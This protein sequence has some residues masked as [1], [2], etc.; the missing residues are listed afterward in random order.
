MLQ[1]IA[2]KD[3]VIE[4]LSKASEM[5]VEAKS[6]QEVKKIMDVAGAAKIYARRQQLGEEAVQHARSIELEAMRRLGELLIETPK[7]S[8]AQGIGKS[9]VPKE[10]HTPTLAELGASK[11]IS[12]LSQQLARMP[13]KE[14]EQVR[15]GIVGMAEALRQAKKEKIISDLE[16]IKNK[17]S[18]KLLGQ[19]DVI[20]IDPPWPMEK[21]VRDVRPNQTNFDYPT[22]SEQEITNVKIPSAADCHLWLWTTQK[23]LTMAFRVLDAWSFNYVCTFV[24]H[25]PGGFQPIGLPQYNCEFALYA[26]KGAPKFIDTKA[27]PTCFSAPRGAHSEKPEEFYDMVRRVTAGRR[28]DM[29]NR[30]KICG[31]ETW[32]NQAA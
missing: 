10:N 21:I 17:K 29:F 20:V 16:S 32:G 4:R 8:G 12:S 25:K 5:L 27:F 9:A 30:R 7:N 18:K 23:F 13:K 26:R 19:Y 22:M 6:M 3:S 1:Q 24:W 14:F 2:I 15:D 28:A 11:K 31:F